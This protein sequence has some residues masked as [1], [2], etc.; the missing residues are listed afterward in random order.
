M[1]RRAAS[2]SSISTEKVGRLYSSTRSQASPPSELRRRH[3]PSS[4]PAGISKLPL[5]EP[6]PLVVTREL[7]TSSPLASIRLTSSSVPGSVA[8]S[9]SSPPPR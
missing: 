8:Y 2:G 7:A 4:L 6:K 1:S 3:W 9:S 5:A